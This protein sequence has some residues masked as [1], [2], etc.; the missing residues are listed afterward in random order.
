[1]TNAK[2]I[3]KSTNMHIIEM[4][5]K[6]EIRDMYNKNEGIRRKVLRCFVDNSTMIDYPIIK[7]N[8]LAPTCQQRR[9][10]GKY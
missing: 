1:M 2:I 3:S 8:R 5:E 10:P 9:E 6:N 7:S 4:Y